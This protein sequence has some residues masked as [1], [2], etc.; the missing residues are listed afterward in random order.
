MEKSFDKLCDV[1]WEMADSLWIHKR[2]ATSAHRRTFDKCP[3]ITDCFIFK[4]KRELCAICS[5]N[6]SES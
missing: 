4:F 3:T 2:S 6:P 5:V 1:C